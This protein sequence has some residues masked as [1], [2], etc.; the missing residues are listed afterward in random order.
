MLKNGFFIF[1]LINPTIMKQVFK[2]ILLVVLF[3]FAANSSLAGEVKPP[4]AVHGVLDL[5]QWDFTKDGPILLNGEWELYW[6]RLLD[7]P[8]MAS[9]QRGSN[10]FYPVPRKTWEGFQL[11]D[12]RVLGATGYATFRLKILLPKQKKRSLKEILAIG[13]TFANSNQILKVVDNQGIP[14]GPSVIKG[15]VGKEPGSSIP[16]WTHKVEPFVHAHEFYL[17]WQISNFHSFRAG[18]QVAPTMGYYGQVRD[19]YFLKIA[20]DFFIIGLLA[21]MAAYHLIIFMLNRS[22][23]ASLWLGLYCLQ[24][25]GFSATVNGYLN[26]FVENTLF[27][28][29]QFK[30]YYALFINLAVPVFLMFIRSVFP[31]QI[32]EKLFWILVYHGVAV[33]IVRLVAPVTWTGYAFVHAYFLL[34]LL[35]L[36]MYQIYVVYIALRTPFRRQAQA[37]LTGLVVLTIASVNDALMVAGFLPYTFFLIP[38]ALFVLI[39]SQALT[40]AVNN[41]ETYQAKIKAEQQALIAERN[42]LENLLALQKAENEKAHFSRMANMDALT[43]I[44]NR[45][46]FDHYLATELKRCSRSGQ[47]ISLVMIDIDFFKQFNDAYGHQGGDECLQ[48]VA[49]II[50][51]GAHRQTDVAARYGGEEFA[52]IAPETTLEGM[53]QICELIRSALKA[54]AIPHKQSK[55]ADIVTLS[56]GVACQHPDQDDTPDLLVQ[57][58]DEALYRAKS[59]GRNRVETTE[60]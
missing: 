46:H 45:R 7:A 41:Q 27:W 58:A 4:V 18:P 30:A 12:G 57:K 13:R 54:A 1:P 53:M 23:R 60:C 51:D 20:Q 56:M 25:A 35:V 39:L 16:V 50:A 38:G 47:P 52:V 11:P 31:G 26:Y 40:V 14:L 29:L 44:A 32:K 34:S 2:R 36:L 42:S 24:I 19:E 5:R 17:I 55:I 48:K 43:Q 8:D 59:A 9:D 15:R 33:A 22:D 3:L 28:E 49:R 6:E 10:G 37:M 21:I